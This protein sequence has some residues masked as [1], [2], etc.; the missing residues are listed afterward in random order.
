MIRLCAWSRAAGTRR[1]GAAS[2]SVSLMCQTPLHTC[3]EDGD[4]ESCGPKVPP[5]P[6]SSPTTAPRLNHETTPKLQTRGRVAAWRCAVKGRRRPRH[7]ERAE[8]GSC[9]QVAGP[10]W[11]LR[12]SSFSFLRGFCF[13]IWLRPHI[14]KYC[15][16]YCLV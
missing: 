10:V 1:A 4:G 6:S 13:Y 9:R 3:S 11:L 16:D 5:P 8:V 2:E 12:N 14:Y 15:P 7:T